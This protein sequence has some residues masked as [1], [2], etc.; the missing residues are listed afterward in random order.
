MA[1]AEKM[2]AT[3]LAFEKKLVSSDGYFYGTTWDKRHQ[4]STPLKLIEKSVRGTI[5]NR[6]NKKDVE[7]FDKDPMKLN[8][9]V[10][11]PNLQKVDACALGEHHDT[12]KLHFT[13]KVLGGV[14]KPSA[15]N[16]EAFNQAYAAA[17]KGYVEQDGFTELAK[18]Y[19]INLANGRYLW[20]NR[21]GAEKVEVVITAGSDTWTFNAHDFSLK[22]FD[23][24]NANVLAL[25]QKIADALSGKI[26]Y[27]LLNVEA[28]ALVGTAQEVYPSEELV[29]DKGK[30]DKSKILYAV[31]DVAAM[32]SQKIGNA[33]RSIDTWYPEYPETGFPIAIEPYG[34]VTNLGKAYRSPKEKVDFYTLFDRFAVGEKLASKEQEHYVMAVLVRGGVFGQSGKE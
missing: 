24:S 28:Y 14:E 31:N 17:A 33:L 9:K 32:H 22:N 25:A 12:L 13:L 27:L 23:S 29:L 8:Q 18:R 6:F 15:C 10:E 2:I 1:K 3:V 19:A 4:A 5:S 21:V 7:S 16:N 30:G 20:R 34:A 26:P 11:S